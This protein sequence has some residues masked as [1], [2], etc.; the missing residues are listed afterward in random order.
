ME[1]L[2]KAFKI[3]NQLR[4]EIFIHKVDSLS[5]ESKIEVQRDIY[6]RIN[7]FLVDANL[8]SVHL[9]YSFEFTFFHMYLIF[10]NKYKVIIIEKVH[11]V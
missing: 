1:T 4:F 7:E 10:V 8:E 11:L 6:H 9:R 5:E 2:T 3:N